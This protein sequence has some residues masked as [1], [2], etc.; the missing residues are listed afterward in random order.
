MRLKT[1]SSHT[2]NINTSHWNEASVLTDSLR[3]EVIS[4]SQRP[5]LMESNRIRLLKFVNCFA[6][7]GTERHVVNLVHG[8][9]HSRFEVHMACLRRLGD[10]LKEIEAS[11]RPLV[12]Y[13]I[14]SLYNHNA[15]IK[16]L[17]FAKYIK[18][19]RIHIVHTYGFYPNVFAI[20]AARLAGAPVIVASIRDTGDMWTPM[21]RRVQKFVCRLAD[22]ILVNAE[23][24]KRWL[25]AEGYAQEKITVI[26]N[27]IDISRFVGKDSGSQ[28]RQELGLPPRAPLIAV[29]ARLNQIKGVEYFLEAAAIIAGRCPEVRFLVVGSGSIPRDGAALEDVVYRRELESYTVR[30]GLE[31]RV[32]FT[33]FRLDVPEVLSEVAVSVLPSFSEGLS[34]TLLESMAAGVPVVATRV[35]GNPEVI[36]DG[37]TGLLVPP[38]DAAALA[39]AIYLLLENPKLASRFGQAGRQRV[40]ELFS[41]ERMIGETERLYLSLLNQARYGEPS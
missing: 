3:P 11:R 14:N 39:D 38:R 22:Q 8:L 18:Q 41:L 2:I 37:E 5:M 30:L 13:P 27:G 28:L 19:N 24:V 7:G 20:L 4:A 21:Q 36:E 16:Q 31:G 12:E 33:G 15:L 17:Q 40:V 32:V 6:I 29:F 23:A 26:K 35:G 34:N 9:D 10:L 25:I 1:N